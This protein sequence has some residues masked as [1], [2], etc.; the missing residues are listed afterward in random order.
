MFSEKQIRTV[1]VVSSAASLVLALALAATWVYTY[2]ILSANPEPPSASKLSPAVS[3]LLVK[4]Q[5][6]LPGRGEIF[7]ALVSAN[8]TDYWPVAMLTISN[9]SDRH[10]L[11]NVTAVIP[12]VSRTFTNT[13]ILGPRETRTIR[14]DVVLT[15]LAFTNTEM[16]QVIL[17]VRAGSPGNQAD[18]AET[19][20]VFLHGV[21]D[22]YWGRKFANAQFIARWVTPH[23]PAVIQLVSAARKYV[24]RGRL[25]GYHLPFGNSQSLVERQVR[26]EA[27]A[28]FLAMSNMGISYVDSLY[29]F[30]NFT[31]VSER[32]RL[33]WETLHLESANCIDVSV[34]YASAME[35]L[36]MHPVIVIVPGHAFTGVRLGPESRDI[37]YVDLTVLPKGTFEDAVA[38][39]GHWLKKTPPNQLLMIDIPAARSLGI[40]PM[41]ETVGEQTM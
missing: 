19:H 20:P 12:D 8:A 13:V 25:A 39:A 29:T 24:P 36:G 41:P 38:R 40:Y 15:P 11:E 37:L 34:A 4:Y 22:I 18:F 16:R 31:S 10:L 32:V 30:G 23:N 17:D 1:A 26:G 28:V 3:P 5:L 35:N 9:L 33:P 27:Q 6:D 7:P 2:Q 21:S 14:I